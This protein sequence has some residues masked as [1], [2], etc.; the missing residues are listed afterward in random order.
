MKKTMYIACGK[1]FSTEK[2]VGEYICRHYS[3][4]N[5][6]V[7][8]LLH[9]IEEGSYTP[10]P[11]V[12]KLPA[13]FSLKSQMPPVYDQAF[14]GTC[15]ANAATALMEYYTGGKVRLSVQYLFERMKRLECQHL[16]EQVAELRQSGEMQESGEKA[17]YIRALIEQGVRRE[18]GSTAHYAFDVLTEYGICSYAKMPYSRVQITALDKIERLDALPPGADEEARRYRISD[19][20]YHLTAPNNVEELKRI[21]AGTRDIEPM[22]VYIGA[23]VFRSGEELMPVEGGVVRLPKIV[24]IEIRKGLCEVTWR[25][26]LQKDFEAVPV[27]P[28][29]LEVVEEVEVLD[30]TSEGGHAMLL[31]GY[32]DDPSC[33]GGG[34]FI[35]RNSWGE[36]SWGE[37]GYARLPYAYAELFIHSAATIVR[38]RPDETTV[39]SAETGPKAASEF[40]AYLMTADRDRADGDGVW[41]ITRGMS[42]LQDEAGVAFPDTQ[43]NRARFKAQGF[44]WTT[45]LATS[46]ASG[47]AKAATRFSPADDARRFFSAFEDALARLGCAFPLLGSVRKPGLFTRSAKVERMEKVGDFSVEL[48]APMRLYALSDAKTIV[49][50]AAVVVEPETAGAVV[51]KAKTRLDAYNLQQRF[52]PCDMSYLVVVSMRSLS[53]D[54]AARIGGSFAQ[55]VLDDYNSTEG[56]RVREAFGETK[57][58]P[59]FL[60]Y[61]VPNTSQQT[62]A[63]FA[64]SWEA[65]NACGGH[66]RILRLAADLGMSEAVLRTWIGTVI[67]GFKVNGDKVVKA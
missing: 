62:T 59:E 17:R 67:T 19:P 41:T 45:Q 66:V 43:E 4:I 37:G 35:V 40:A 49:R 18:G 20:V 51:E 23:P 60:A 58:A 55:I 29:Q 47:E 25:D 14:R 63:R 16:A 8:G 42:I 56:Y 50:I 12:M 44:S 61:L 22:P 24:P 30:M 1:F 9:R 33:P 36:E 13:S 46:A 15:A 65:V 2:D 32:E 57:N 53:E 26:A 21:L 64:R 6:R 11:S 7:L 5:D 10:V 31:V 39:E 38:R 27:D 34:A 3:V 52:S 28:E 48:G 54:V